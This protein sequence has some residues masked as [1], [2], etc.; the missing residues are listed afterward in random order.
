LSYSGRETTRPDRPGPLVVLVG[1]T[2]VGKTAL[3][4][5]F[6]Q[7]WRHAH[8]QAVEILSAD[9]RQ[10]YR[11][12]DIGT[13]K[14]TVAERQG[15]PHH[16]I[17]LVEPTEDFTLANYQDRAYAAIDEILGRGALPMLVG[18]TG[19]YVRAVVDG[20]RLPRVA[21]DRGL[22]KDLEQFAQSAGPEALHRRL[23]SLDP[24]AADR[25]DPRNVRRV[26]RALEVTLITERPF[27]DNLAGEPRYSVC[28]V[29]LTTERGELYRR[30]D[31]RVDEQMAAGLLDETRAAIERGCPPDRPALTG[32]GYRQMV[33]VIEGRMSLPEAVQ[34]YKFETHRFARQQ[35]TWFRLDD[36]SIRWLL[37]EDAA[38]ECLAKIAERCVRQSADLNSGSRSSEYE[39]VSE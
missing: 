4:I 7:H 6:A 21:P 34:R 12:L 33:A 17:D 1:P 8:G 22:R 20:V 38:P 19:L 23:N 30:I 2:A 13:A 32:F 26:V 25:I 29:G 28:Q 15:V 31:L 37:A 36:S 5:A 3:S 9:S 35:Y 14:P 18:G 11:E 27:S 16:L 10:V 39:Y 24:V